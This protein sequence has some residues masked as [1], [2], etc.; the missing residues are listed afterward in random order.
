MLDTPLT[1]TQAE[2]EPPRAMRI[3]VIDDN[4]LDRQQ[5]L[6]LCQRAGLA[7]E[8]VEISDLGALD[9]ALSATSFD[10][11]FIDYLLAGETGLDALDR[12]NAHD[13]QK[14]AAAIMLAGQGQINIAVEAMRRGCADYLTKSMM[15]VE[16]LQKSIATA[17]ERRMLLTTIDDERAARADMERSICAYANACT[18]EMRTILSATLRRVR[19]LRTYGTELESDYA[20][21]L[22]TLETDIDRLWGALPE[23]FGHKGLPALEK[24]PTPDAPAQLV[25]R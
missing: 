19:K 5:V 15:T 9:R 6:R 18:S 11:V 13:N 1:T 23:F 10:L 25:H 24:F 16:T 20:I 21:D 7:F 8:A 22:N 2:T 17:L 4:E 12:L 3:L 14:S